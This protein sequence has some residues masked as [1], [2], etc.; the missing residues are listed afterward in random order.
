MLLTITTTYAPATDL[1][2]L[3]H[4]NPARAQSFELSFGQAHVFYSEASEDR[5]TAALLL[6]VDPV[7]LVRNRRGPAGESGTSDS[8]VN[9]RP[10]VASSFLSVAVAQVF[11]SALAGRCKDRSE[12]ADAELPLQARLAVVPCRGGEAFLRRLFEPLGYDVSAVRHPLDE[13]FPDWG[14]GPYFTVELR[15][16]C[17]LRDLL[18]HLYVLVPVLD[19]DKHYW[20]GDDEVDKLLRHGAGWLAAHPERDAIARRYLRQQSR[21]ARTALARL[22][23]E[24][25]PDPDAEAEA[26]A[27]EEA[28][29]EQRLSLNEQRL[30]AVLAV[31][32]ESAAQRVLDLGCGEGKLIRELL[33]DRTFTEVV[34]VDVSFRSLEIARERLH[35]DRLPPAQ[36]QRIKLLHGSL[37][38]RD[39][40]LAGYDAA[41]VVEVVEHLDPPRL[42]AFERVLFE[43][44]RPG[45]VVLTTPNA[46]YNV[47]FEGL[48]AGSFRHRDHRFEWTRA[49]FRAWVEGVAGRFGYEVRF[50]P[51]GPEDADVGAPTQMGVFTR[52]G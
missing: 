27:G 12:L 43:F 16:R 50:L 1:G 18:T 35:W 39:R 11:G 51:V 33:K 14:E 19:A 48:P 32:K 37:T 46:E 44:V 6:D 4:K 40:R 36:Q 20:V 25:H 28:V 29:V 8:Y 49:E 34:G 42:T 13:S 38:Y 47:K 9:D 7:G 21:L 2:Y 10:Y 3:L 24:D 45:C 23:E 26:R 30:G 31:L 41:A 52:C 22:A 17:R 5:C 15:R